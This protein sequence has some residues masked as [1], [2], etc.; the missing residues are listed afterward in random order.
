M[1]RACALALLLVIGG[2]SHQQ[3]PLAPAGDQ[4]VAL[5][6]LLILMFIVSGLLYASVLVGLCWSVLRGKAAAARKINVAHEP[7]IDKGLWGAATVITLALTALILASFL[8]D[9]ALF[10]TRTQPAMLVRITAHQWWWRIEYQD[11]ATGKW[12]ETANELHLPVSR[13][14]RVLV[15][16]SDVIHSFWVPNIA[17]KIDM[18][19]GRPNQLDLTPRR[20]GWY[21]GQC[22]EYCGAQHAHMAL[23]VRIED[24]RSFDSW[25]AR[26]A[27]PAQLGSLQS[28]P[29]AP[30]FDAH[31][32]SCHVIRGTSAK[33]KA[34]P[35]LT[36]IAG[37]RSIAA[38]T[39]PMTRGGLQGWIVQPQALKPGTMMPASGLSAS[40]ADAVADYLAGLK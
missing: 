36:H 18:V 13:T 10:S 22:A 6:Q 2:C 15:R 29:G 30:V 27:A 23:D 32:A 9:R 35:D 24:A 25:L 8:A 28:L 26:Q 20:L 14:T 19:P 11:A 4:A 16:T 37:R 7:S 21:R 34:G 40:R 17:G 5:H 3:S 1:K 38:G 33:G 31:C 39:L 12:I